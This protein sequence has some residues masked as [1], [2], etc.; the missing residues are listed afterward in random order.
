MQHALFLGF[1]STCAIGLGLA[2]AIVVAVAVAAGIAAFLFG[3]FGC[4]SSF[5]RRCS[6]CATFLTRLAMAVAA[7]TLG[8]GNLLRSFCRLFCDRFFSYSVPG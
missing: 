6:I 7:G 4:W 5:R 2:V 3:V 1:I 8:A